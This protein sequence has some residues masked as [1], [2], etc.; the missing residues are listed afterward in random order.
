MA[1]IYAT[2]QQEEIPSTAAIAGH[3]IHPMLIPLPIASLVGALVADIIYAV[4]KRWFWSEA[5]TRLTLAGFITGVVAAIFGGIDFW[6]IRR[7]Q[8]IRIAWI[9]MIGNAIAL[10]LALISLRVR[11]GNPR[12]GTARTG[13]ILSV[14]INLI[15]VVTGWLGGELSYRHKV[16]VNSRQSKLK[17]QY[18]D[19]NAKQR[20]TQFEWTVGEPAANEQR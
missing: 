13:L 12:S 20:A 14:L 8:E 9:H 18:H 3:P 16:G 19:S 4:N 2:K 6:T 1:R 7:V 17:G 10:L 15:L 11:V 5:A